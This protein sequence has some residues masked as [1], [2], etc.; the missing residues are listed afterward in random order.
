[1]TPLPL[2]APL[3]V[4]ATEGVMR[5]CLHAFGRV[6][7]RVTGECMR[8]DLPPGQEVTI[9]RQRPRLGDVVLVSQGQ[10]LRLH[11]LVF[12]PPARWSWRTK[13]DGLPGLDPPVRAS[14]VLG[15]VVDPRQRRVGRALLA[16]AQAAWARWRGASR[17]RGA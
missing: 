14:D 9:A 2:A 13:G 1:M 17:G 15:T 5:E 6:R 3:D 7:F 8:P 12:A 4:E 16:C 10:G 11:R